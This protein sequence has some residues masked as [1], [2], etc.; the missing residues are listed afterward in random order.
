MDTESVV[1]FETIELLRRLAEKLHNLGAVSD[2]LTLAAAIADVVQATRTPAF[3]A[4]TFFGACPSCGDCEEVLAID[5]K[6]Y[7]VCHEHRV[8]WYI[9]TDRLALRDDPP[10]RL[11]QN[12]SVLAPYREV[13][14]MEAFAQNACS[15]CGLA[16][17]HASW[18]IMSGTTR[19]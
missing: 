9:G 3:Y 15:C 5:N 19:P 17:E 16:I 7:S 13:A 12:R 8:Y 10:E 11:V 14:P 18:C 2:A 1:P 4:E 6:R